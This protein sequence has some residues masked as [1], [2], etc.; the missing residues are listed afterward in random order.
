MRIIR[1]VAGLR[2]A[3]AEAKQAGAATV[4]LVPTMGALHE[5]HLSLMRAARAEND[6]VVVSIFVN[7]TQFNEASDLA[8]YPRQEDADAALAASAGVDLIFAPEV[9]EIYPTG[10]ATTVSVAGSITERLEGAKRG[11]SHFDG[12]ATVVSKLLIAVAPDSAYFGQKDAQQLI[13][14]RR[15]VADLG[16]PTRIVGCPT[17]RDDDGLARSSRNVLLTADDRDRA[18]AIP[19]ALEAIAGLARD[20]ETDAATLRAAGL[21]VLAEQSIT[22]EYLAIVDRTTLEDLTSVAGHVLC[23]VAARVGDVRLIDNVLLGEESAA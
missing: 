9:T 2:A 11:S 5:G 3:I 14:V 17:S 8:A 12:V 23:A 18:L 20:G 13:V 6:L 1:T 22:P 19:R 21:A 15:M 7:P 16:I 4:G 10:F